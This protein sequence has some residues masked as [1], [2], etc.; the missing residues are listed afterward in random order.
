MRSA[1]GFGNCQVLFSLWFPNGRCD[2]VVGKRRDA[3]GLPFVQ[4]ASP[5]VSPAQRSQTGSGSIALGRSDRAYPRT[6][7]EFFQCCLST[8]SG[9]ACGDHLFHWWSIPHALR[10]VVRR[11]RSSTDADVWTTAA[12]NAAAVWTTT[13]KYRVTTT[14]I[15]SHARELAWTAEHRGA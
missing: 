15:G 12:G 14:S 4:R 7:C 11:R 10:R 13:T 6:A 1:T 3:V 5:D 2:S 8:N 9:G